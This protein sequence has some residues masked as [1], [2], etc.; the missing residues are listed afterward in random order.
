MAESFCELPLVN[1][2]DEEIVSLLTSSHT[3]A[4]VGLSDKPERESHQVALYLKSQGYRIIPVNPNLTEVLGERAYASLADI[5][6]SIAVDVVD[7]FRKPEFIPE[8]VDQAI[9]RKVR[10]VWMQKGLAHNAA[11]ERA[12]AAGLVVVMDRCMMV[13]HRRLIARQ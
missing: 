1:A 7:I 4:V 8:I 13:E 12:R 11:A 5:P 9:A 2:N 6:D 10:G 3:V